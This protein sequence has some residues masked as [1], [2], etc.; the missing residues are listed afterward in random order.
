MKS[1]INIV[2]KIL[3]EGIEKTDRTGTGTIAIAGAMFEHDMSTGFPL[4]TTKRM[5][6]KTMAVELEFFIKGYTDKQWL[7]E[8]GCRI[9]DEWANPGIVPY[10]HDDETKK[11]MAAERDLGPVYGFQWRHFG[12]E[13]RGYDKD[14]TGQGID[15]LAFI[16]KQLKERPDDRRMIM[17]AWNPIQLPQMALAPCHYSLQVTVLENK[18]NLMWNQRSVDTMLGL[19]FN[20]A[21]YGLLLHLIAK[22]TCLQEGRLV[23]FLGDTHIYLNHVETARMQI[24]R[25]PFPLPTVQTDNFTSIF[26]WD[27]T[28]TKFNNYRHHPSI[29]Y[30]IAV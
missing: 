24:E 21:S 22:E 30:P 28:K 17:S 1:Y 3:A 20:V 4:L 8:R 9:W 5:A 12:A 2:K 15:Q 16:V 29:S 13:Y 18:L 10:G 26:E 6:N 7:Q 25:E 14:H 23:G 27:H 11:R 19:P